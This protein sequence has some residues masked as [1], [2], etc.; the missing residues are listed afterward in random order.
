MCLR[1][2]SAEILEER[3]GLGLGLICSSVLDLLSDYKKSISNV[4]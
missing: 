1:Q 4:E 3:R 2:E